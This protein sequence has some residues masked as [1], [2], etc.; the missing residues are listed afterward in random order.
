MSLQPAAT[1]STQRLRQTASARGRSG[2]TCARKML[3]RHGRRRGEGVGSDADADAAETPRSPHPR[4][5]KV[6]TSRGLLASR[7]AS[8]EMNMKTKEQRGFILAA[9]HS[10]TTAVRSFDTAEH[11]CEIKGGVCPPCNVG[12]LCRRHDLLRRGQGEKA[13]D[14]SAPGHGATR[15]LTLT[16]R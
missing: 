14:P 5:E 1:K 16:S 11:G 9:C 8:N 6:S 3:V 2:W 15:G 7:A 12:V 13:R 10:A 4:L